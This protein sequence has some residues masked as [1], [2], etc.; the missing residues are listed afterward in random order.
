LAKQYPFGSNY[1]LADL[2]LPELKVLHVKYYSVNEVSLGGFPKLEGFKQMGGQITSLQVFS[3]NPLIK[4]IFTEGTHG[5]NQTPLNLKDLDRNSLLEDLAL[6]GYRV[7]SSSEVPF[8]PALKNLDLSDTGLR[9][10]R[11][12]EA[13]DSLVNVNL[14]KNYQLKDLS[15]LRSSKGLKSLDITCTEVSDLGPVQSQIDQGLRV[16]GFDEH[17]KCWN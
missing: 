16:I 6:T 15:P 8:L 3:K 10:L 2:I 9:S 1:Q 5:Y 4:S 11:S 7:S 13:M 14:R 12:L 17:R